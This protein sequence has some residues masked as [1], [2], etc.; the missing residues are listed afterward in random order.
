MAESYV[1]HP[2]EEGQRLDHFLTRRFPDIS[3]SRLRRWLDDGRITIDGVASIKAGLALRAGWTVRI[4]PPEPEISTLEPEP[5]AMRIVHEDDDLIVIDKP[6]GLTVHP[7][8]GRRTGTLVHGL[9]HLHPTRIWP[10]PPERPGIVHRLDRET[11]GLLVIACNDRAYLDLQGQISRR[12]AH[13]RYICLVWGTPKPAQGIID[14]PMGRDPKDR[15]RMAVVSQGGRPARTGYRVLRE[16]GPLS[17]LEIRL[18]TGRTHQI[19]VHLSHIGFPVFGDPVYGGGRIFLRRLAPAVRPVWSD[20]LRRLN[21]QALHAYHLSVRHPRDGR[22]WLFE[23]PV[24]GEIEFL[25]RE[26]E[27]DA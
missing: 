25:L 7:G 1:I 6:A 4:E 11:S 12:E 23:A 18:E 13:R 27:G 14:A 8:A 15:R 5:I 24:P 17:L 3:R 16:Y 21:R 10:G 2:D 20:R 22:G 9:L 26:L 19:R